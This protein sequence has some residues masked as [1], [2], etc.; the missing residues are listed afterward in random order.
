M[1]LSSIKR[2]VAAAEDGV[3]V[4][5]ALGNLDLLIAAVGNKQYTTMLRKL[6][7]PYKRNYENM[8]DSVFVGLQNKCLAKTVLLGWRNMEAEED[9]QPDIE[10]SSEQAYTLLADPENHKFRE[11]VLALA[12]EEEVFNKEAVEAATFQA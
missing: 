1:K 6:M 5:G 12:E 3:W 2:D 11:T 9:G 8:E 7:K 10:Y 4:T